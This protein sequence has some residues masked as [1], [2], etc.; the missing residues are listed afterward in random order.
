MVKIP[1]ESWS[2]TTVQ[3][4]SGDEFFIQNPLLPLLQEDLSKV[5]THVSCINEHAVYRADKNIVMRVCGIRK[6]SR[7]HYEFKTVYFLRAA[8]IEKHNSF[9]IMHSKVSRE[10]PVLSRALSQAS[11]SLRY[12]IEES[13]LLAYNDEYI[14]EDEQGHFF[15]VRE[16]NIP[17]LLKNHLFSY[18][19]E[20]KSTERNP[21]HYL[22]LSQAPYLYI[23]TSLRGETIIENFP[24]NE[25]KNQHRNFQGK[26]I[27][28][29]YYQKRADYFLLNPHTL[30]EYDEVDLYDILDFFTDKTSKT[31]SPASILSIVQKKACL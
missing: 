31:V 19:Y 17:S 3:L 21:V 24:S 10:Y 8:R 11:R 18:S 13:C 20:R 15:I 4:H 26:L 5:A 28:N 12:N 6:H 2:E 30:F 7:K 23:S 9:R 14:F 22:F 25:W 29:P 27:K 16:K 1:Y